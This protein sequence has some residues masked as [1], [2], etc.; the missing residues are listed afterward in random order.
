MPVTSTEPK[1]TCAACGKDYRW[2]P[3]LAGKKAKCKCGAVIAVPSQAPK[4]AAPKPAAK[5]KPAEQDMDFDGLYA[6]AQEE[7]KASARQPTVVDESA[8]GYRCPSCSTPLPPGAAVC[9]NCRTDLRTGLRIGAGAAGGAG[10]LAAAGAYAS[11][12]PTA[13]DG[14]LPYGGGS[15]GAVAAGRR[16][17]EEILYEG[18]K[19][20][21][22][23]LP[24]GLIVLGILF[25]FGSVAFSGDK[26]TAGVMV[27]LVGARV[28]MDSVL[29]FIAMLIAV[30]GFDMGFGAFGPAVLKILAIALGPGA[31]GQMLEKMLGGQIGAII[32]GGVVTIILYYTL[33]KVLFNLDLGET[34]LLVF[35]IYGVRRVL[36]TFLFVALIGLASSGALSEEGAVA[37]G[38]GTVAVVTAGE[39]GEP[40]PPKEML[41]PE[42]IAY[43][44]DES[45]QHTLTALRGGTEA[46]DWLSGDLNTIAGMDLD[47]SR[48]FVADL[49]KTGVT[50]A[51]VTGHEQ[52]T[53]K[54]G[55]SAAVITEITVTLP[56]D[57]AA[58]KQVWAVR[59]G[60]E[61]KLGL[62]PETVQVEV[63]GR[64]DEP[65]KREPMKDW[66]QKFLT[67][68]L[69]KGF[70]LDALLDRK[71]ADAADEDD[72][73]EG[74]EAKPKA[75]TPEAPAVQTPAPQTPADGTAPAPAPTAQPAPSDSPF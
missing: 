49:E 12:T 6:L 30:R 74:D 44:L 15:G 48:K 41:S 40:V 42:V 19:F 60:L 28:I 59:E 21:S 10:V 75:A 17:D 9:S 23:Y 2:K 1:F 55:V 67:I 14:V 39:D 13:R 56:T 61:K 64:D 20:R 25:Y 11:A 37:I 52:V 65:K 38:G 68:R 50:S 33:I 27:A 34:F 16:T 58:R 8:A 4:V 3:E 18:G 32:I 29:I 35:L 51:I 66:G 71:G 43:R 73:D 63:G 45:N 36:G 26:L 5:P 72:E 62:K 53:T 46:H 31:L 24:L 70:D 47:Q 22:L 57:P 7:N 69:A 54:E